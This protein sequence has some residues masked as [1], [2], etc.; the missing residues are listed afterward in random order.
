M[1]SDLEAGPT[2]SADS[3][4][5]GISNAQY[6]SLLQA[7]ENATNE[8]PKIQ[9]VENKL[10]SNFSEDYQPKM[11]SLGP[12]HHSAYQ[13]GKGYD[14]KQKLKND[15]V[16]ASSKDLLSLELQ[17]ENIQQLR[18]C[19]NEEVIEG[20]NDKELASMLCA[21]GCAILQYISSQPTHK[22]YEDFARDILLLE[23]Q[24]PYKVLKELMRLS[25]NKDELEES[26]V[27]FIG[28]HA[29]LPS[30]ANPQQ[31]VKIDGDHVHLL[32]LLRTSLL[33]N[34]Q[35]ETPNSSKDLISNRNVQ[36]LKEAG[37][38]LRPSIDWV[39]RKIAFIR[40]FY[41]LGRL[42]L[43]PIIVDNS[44]RVKFLNLVAYEMCPD[45]KKDSGVISYLFFLSS[46]ITEAQDVKELKVAGVL[47]NFG[48]DTEL[49]NLFSKI[50]NELG[51]DP[52]NYIEVKK[53]IQ[54]YYG[55]LMSK[56]FQFYHAYI[57]G[58]SWPLLVTFA[59]L[60]DLFF[61]GTQTLIAL[62]SWFSGRPAPA[63]APQSHS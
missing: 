48:S 13:R 18:D 36:E 61:A 11:V 14:Y 1:S 60:L 37:I 27:K 12:I 19:F 23:N 31:D 15:F 3:G 30:Q 46:L 47:Y 2:S 33:G 5:S 6:N 42:S 52:D 45:F 43:P 62:M 53:N 26:I 51:S 24:I 38:H 41:L 8:S 58:S 63:P 32:D 34:S 28:K 35:A 29:H 17:I 21:D 57:K 4:D 25:N 49:P 39:W 59:V 54:E 7:D 20:L 56:M 50:R 10:R 22:A 16:Q 40:Q 9:M 55:T 44:T